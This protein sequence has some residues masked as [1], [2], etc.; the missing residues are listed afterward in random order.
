MSNEL[1]LTDLILEVQAEFAEIIE[2]VVGE[3]L[4]PQMKRM[5]TMQFAGMDP[6]EKEIIRQ[7]DPARFD[8]FEQFLNQ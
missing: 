6:D 7:Q 1:D 5:M 4:A 3:L 8:R 2:E